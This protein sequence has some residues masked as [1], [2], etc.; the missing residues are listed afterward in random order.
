MDKF[1][2][3]DPAIKRKMFLK[4]TDECIGIGDLLMED[5]TIMDAKK[6][7]QTKSGVF[8]YFVMEYARP[9]KDYGV[10]QLDILTIL[11]PNGEVGV[12][13]VLFWGECSAETSI[14]ATA[15]FSMDTNTGTIAEAIHHS[16]YFKFPKKNQGSY[17]GKKVPGTLE[18]IEVC[19]KAH[20]NI[21]KK[22]EWVTVIG[23]DCMRDDRGKMVFFEG[24][25]GTLRTTRRMFIHAENTKD[26]IRN[27]F[28]PYDTNYNITP[29]R[30]PRK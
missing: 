8:E 1:K 22:H 4:R 11:N 17:L 10:H 2:N 3:L 12:V 24:N 18:A 23:W 20:K 7:L 27:Y 19:K 14:S 29:G 6:E 28:W 9:H 26:F 16:Y 21:A 30:N 5:N 15:G 25:F 13:S